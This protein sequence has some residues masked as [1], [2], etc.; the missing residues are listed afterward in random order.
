MGKQWKLTDFIFLGPKSLQVVTTTM[1]LK[2]TSP[3][4]M[5]KE[6]GKHENGIN[7]RVGQG[8]RYSRGRNQNKS[9]NRKETINRDFWGWGNFPQLKEDTQ[10]G[11]V[12]LQAKW[13]FKAQQQADTL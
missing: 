7:R 10:E 11:P 9:Q 2:D 6:M 12:L 4:G 5:Q 1:K 13:D 3:P 8:A